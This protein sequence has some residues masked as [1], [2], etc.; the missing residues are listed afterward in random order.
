VVVEMRIDLTQGYRAGSS[1][2][3]TIVIRE[4]E[5]NQ[6]VCFTLVLDPLGPD[7]VTPWDEQD[8]QRHFLS[9]HHHFYCDG[10]ATRRTAG[11]SD[12]HGVTIRPDGTVAGR[13][14]G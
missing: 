13:P 2:E 7:D 5:V 3:A 10:N 4:K 11:T 1:Y 12:T 14:E 8:L 6:N 9:W